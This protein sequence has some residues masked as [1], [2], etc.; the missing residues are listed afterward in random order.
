MIPGSGEL[1]DFAISGIAR[2]YRRSAESGWDALSPRVSA[3]DI[4]ALQMMWAL[5]GDI[6][7]VASRVAENPRSLAGGM[8]TETLIES[9][10]I[11]GSVDA[12]ATLLEQMLTG[13][14]TRYVVDAPA[15][16]HATHRNHVLAWVLREAERLLVAL[17][18]SDDLSPDFE[19]IHSR[20]ALLETALRARVLND[21]LHSPLG[22]TR[23]SAAALRDCKKSLNT[24]YRTAASA[25]ETLAAIEELDGEA[26]SRV[27]SD[28]L[29]SRL[30]NWQK[31]ELC[32]AIAAAE[33][34]QV[35]SGDPLVWKN[36][37]TARPSIEVGEISVS[38]Q[39]TV[40]SRDDSQLDPSEQLVRKLLIGLGANVGAS[41]AD[42]TVAFNK[43][44]LC[45]IE[46]KWF[47]SETRA[48]S[49]IVDAT[50]QL[51]RYA[52]DSRPASAAAAEVMLTNCVILCASTGTLP[53]TIDG[54]AGVNLL[55]FRGLTEG[56]LATWAARVVASV[57]PLATAAS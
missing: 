54:H 12:R 24:M 42:V 48:A 57:A 16:S 37:F 25:F 40:A 17:A 26:I 33:A 6:G 27:V 35:A 55:G 56:A 38:W 52:R 29:V 49:A 22:R 34:I 23:P 21:V 4:D 13:D 47:E 14:P 53:P 7:S 1:S 39:Y 36:S 30:E 44:D 43:I 2:C 18:K 3:A 15:I 31:L 10:R 8:T 11:S 5:S 51:V 50:E 46:C 41:R 32:A 20:A 9:G 19:W 45:H 28:A